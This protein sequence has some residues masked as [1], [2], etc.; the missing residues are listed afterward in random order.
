MP[1][2]LAAARSTASTPQV[3]VVVTSGEERGYWVVAPAERTVR[4]GTLADRPAVV[5][6]G[7]GPV[8][9]LFFAGGL[10][11]KAAVAHEALRVQGD[12]AAL[13]AL[14]QLLRKGR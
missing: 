5:V 3:G 4:R 11:V 12:S 1:S 9:S 10:D 14:A 8:L 13:S 6:E 2:A 7:D